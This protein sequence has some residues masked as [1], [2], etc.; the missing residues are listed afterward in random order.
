MAQSEETIS[1][2]F[3]RVFEEEMQAAIEDIKRDYNRYFPIG[4][5]TPISWHKALRIKLWWKRRNARERVAKKIAPWL[6]GD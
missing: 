2:S 1:G 3:K 5:V 4:P 6:S